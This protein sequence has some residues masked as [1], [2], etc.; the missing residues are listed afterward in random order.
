MFGFV[1]VVFVVF[2]ACVAAV[3]ASGGDLVAWFSARRSVGQTRADAMSG[4]GNGCHSEGLSL[5]GL[6][7]VRLLT[8]EL[9]G[10]SASQEHARAVC[11][12][13]FRDQLVWRGDLRS[14]LDLVGDQVDVAVGWLEDQGLVRSVGGWV[15]WTACLPLWEAARL[16]AVSVPPPGIRVEEEGGEWVMERLRP[17]AVPAGMIKADRR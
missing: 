13:V 2:V 12:S 7:A 4:C 8:E 5:R 17:R 14:R 16:R 1:G 10:L 6:R 3:C 11:A 9:G 15:Q